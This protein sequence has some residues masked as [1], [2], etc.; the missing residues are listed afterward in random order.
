[1]TETLNLVVFD[2]WSIVISEAKNMKHFKLPQTSSRY[3]P[4]EG[5]KMN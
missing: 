3:Q 2:G 5:K 4:L 1:M